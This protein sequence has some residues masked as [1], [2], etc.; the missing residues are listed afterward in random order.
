MDFPPSK[1]LDELNDLLGEVE[2]FAKTQGVA[3]ALEDR[4]LN[5][6]FLL[7]AAQAM[8]LYAK[9]D[10]KAAADDFALLSEEILGRLRATPPS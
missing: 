2:S 10:T 3:S 1:Y 4:K 5:S 9:G 7:L 6:S 8:R